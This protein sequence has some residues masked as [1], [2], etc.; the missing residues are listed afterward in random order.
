[1]KKS[2]KL[3][4]LTILILV[5]G[6]VFSACIK[7][8]AVNSNLNINTATTTEE[9]DTSDWKTYRNEELG[10]EFKYPKDWIVKLYSYKDRDYPAINIVNSDFEDP[11][12]SDNDI[13]IVI[14]SEESDLLLTDWF[15]QR[16]LYNKSN[17]EKKIEIM[18]Q[19][20]GEWYLLEKDFVL[21]ETTYQLNDLNGLV[22]YVKFLKPISLEGAAPTDKIYNFKV[23]DK[24]YTLSGFTYTGYYS[25]GLIQIFDKI[26]STISFI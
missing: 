14:D 13:R 22:R 26:V 20:L 15:N 5:L 17:L 6:T 21:K 16:T 18:N 4:I 19:E 11:Y 1:M 7:K 23:G 25:D 3:T 10:V 12:G 24:I 2:I 9:T 8:P